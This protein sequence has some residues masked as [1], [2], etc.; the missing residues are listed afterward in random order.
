[1]R[2]FALDT[3]G[4]PGSNH[5]VPD[6]QPSEGQVRVRVAAASLNPFDSAVIQG[7]AKDFMEHRFPLIPAGDLAGTVDA[8]GPDV[9]GLSVGDSVFG[10]TGKVFQGEGT[11]A[12]LTTASVGTIAKRPSSLGEVEAAALPLAGVSAQMTVEAA[13]LKPKDVVVV[14][15]ASGGIGGYAVQLARLQGAHLIGVTSKG[16]TE[17]V[18]SLGADEVIDRTSGDVLEM[19][20]SKHPDGVA[21]IIDTGSDAPSFA[22]LSE[23]V[24]K[25]G[26]AISMKRSAAVEDLAKRGVTGVNVTTKVTTER[27]ER[28]AKLAADGKLKAPRIR[29]FPLEQA[30]EA[31]KLLGEGG[32]H[33]KIVV[34]I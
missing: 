22:R 32:A 7:Y 21:S 27:L 30:N 31:F 8:L 17:Y 12:E 13:A 5:N 6:P 14:V 19:L 11:L 34:K 33:G 3:F 16:N 15:G 23:A 18:K 4:Q 20:K 26:T 10:V 1:M 2:A 9:T 25:G 24:R 28:L 29:T